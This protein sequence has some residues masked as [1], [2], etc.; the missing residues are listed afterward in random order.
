MT[1]VSSNAKVGN[2]FDAAH[3]STARE[4]IAVEPWRTQILFIM[5]SPSRTRESAFADVREPSIVSLS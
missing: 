5:R 3:P 1:R 4:A 2:S